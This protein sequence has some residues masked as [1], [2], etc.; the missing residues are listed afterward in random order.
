MDAHNKRK[1][2]RG[3]ISW[4]LLAMGRKGVWISLLRQWE[5]SGKA[6]ERCDLTCSFR[7]SLWRLG[8]LSAPGKGWEGSGQEG[9]SEAI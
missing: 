8:E 2:G 5:N 6:G 1:V 3:Q 4:G 9:N 7:P